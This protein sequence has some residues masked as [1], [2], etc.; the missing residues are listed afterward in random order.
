[1]LDRLNKLFEQAKKCGIASLPVKDELMKR[2][3]ERLNVL[4]KELEIGEPYIL[5]CRNCD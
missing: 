3:A 4:C 1:M 5:K 2:R